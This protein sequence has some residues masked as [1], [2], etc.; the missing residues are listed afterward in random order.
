LKQVDPE[1]IQWRISQYKNAGGG[2]WEPQSRMEMIARQV[3]QIY[4]ARLF[5]IQAMDFDDLLLHAVRVLEE[6][7][8]VAETWSR[9]LRYIHVDEYQDTNAVQYR[10]VRLL[11]QTHRNVCVVG[12]ADQAIYRWRGA[13]VRNILQFEADFP[14]ATVIKLEQNY[15]S[16]GTILEA[17]NAVI[18]HNT[19]RKEKRLWSTRGP[20]RPILVYE[21]LDQRDEAMY[22]AGAIKDHVAAGGA[23]ND[24]AVLYRV[25][26]QSRPVEEAL[27]QHGIPYRIVGGLTFYDRKEIRDL[28]AY[29]RLIANPRDEVSLLRIIN[30][31]KRGLGEGSV[32]RLLQFARQEGISLLEAMGRAQE[33]DLPA[34]ARESAVEFAQMIEEL[35]LWQEGMSV[36]EFVKEVLHQTGY[37]TLFDERKREDR[38]RLENLDE[39]LSVTDH[40][41]RRRGGGL[42]EFLAEVALLSDVDKQ[43]RDHRDA[44]TLMTLHAAKGL[45]F[46]VVFMIGMEE[47]LFPHERSMDDPEGIEEE[48]NLCYVGITRAMDELHLVYCAERTIYGQTTG[49]EPSR[50]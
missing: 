8:S 14:D 45:E 46:P 30:V 49:R 22:V 38:S 42:V 33:A 16:T 11:S 3:H 29:L 43:R 41:D 24:C 5:Q 12:D 47:G 48:R 37:R 13:D 20:G 21:A 28:L 10:L 6:H 50:F 32:E 26:A 19:R 1:G 15:R 31:P 18:A 36:T 44:V 9:R 2:Q 27:L 40:F 7:P 25:G 23:L 34:K 17:A 39:F 35:R 4:Q